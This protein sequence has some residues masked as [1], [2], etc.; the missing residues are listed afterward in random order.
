MALEKAKRAL[1]TEVSSMVFLA[2]GSRT[3]RKLGPDLAL[4]HQLAKD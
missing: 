2:T 4:M 1:A 3:H